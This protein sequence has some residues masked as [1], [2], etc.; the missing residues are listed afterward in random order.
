MIICCITINRVPHIH[1][2][3]IPVACSIIPGTYYV[4]SGTM[5]SSVKYH[6]ISIDLIL[7]YIISTIFGTPPA[8]R[9]AVSP[10][11]NTISKFLGS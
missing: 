11:L 4:P 5:L 9:R 2:L 1:V 8:T 3:L 10:R 7:L 6:D